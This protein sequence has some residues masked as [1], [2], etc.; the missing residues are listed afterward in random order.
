MPSPKWS[1]QAAEQVAGQIIEMTHVKS[2]KQR[3][4]LKDKVLKVSQK[5]VRLVGNALTKKKKKPISDR[6]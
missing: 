6:E 2:D 3:K 5:P 4:E 1:E